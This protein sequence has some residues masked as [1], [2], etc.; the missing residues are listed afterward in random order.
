MIDQLEMLLAHQ[1][2]V[3]AVVEFVHAQA[4]TVRLRAV[5]AVGI[6]IDEDGTL[7]CVPWSS[8]KSLSVVP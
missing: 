6:A 2:L 1:G 8:I 4:T 3:S 7:R 5:D